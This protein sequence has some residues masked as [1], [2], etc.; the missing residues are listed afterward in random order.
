MAVGDDD[1]NVYAFRGANVA[2]IQR[3]QE[4]Y[5]RS[6][7]VYM[8]EN[9]RSSGHI[10]SAANQLIAA[11]RDRMKGDHPIRINRR[12]KNDPPGGPW[13]T[14]DPLGPRPRAA[15]GRG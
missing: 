1:Q 15:A 11:N 12:R 6:K 7:T 13:D 3:F 2:F 10:I 9:F 8:V 14:T 5:T 4:D